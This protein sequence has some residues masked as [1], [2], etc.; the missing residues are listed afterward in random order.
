M[1]LYYVYKGSFKT[2]EGTYR[3]YVGYT[4]TASQREDL[5]TKGGVKWT[6]PHAERH[7]QDGL[8]SLGHK[9]QSCCEVQ[10]L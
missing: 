8:F 5:L 6:K 1:V 9:E 4:G 3:E 7:L 2:K 10:I